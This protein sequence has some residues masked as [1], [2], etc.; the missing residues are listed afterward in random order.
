MGN[1]CMMWLNP[2]TEQNTMEVEPVFIFAGNIFGDITVGQKNFA[3]GTAVAAVYALGRDALK[4]AS[5]G[6]A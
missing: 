6:H 4:Q 3:V 1:L 5:K 2:E